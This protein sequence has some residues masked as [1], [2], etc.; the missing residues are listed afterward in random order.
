VPG[1]QRWPRRAKKIS[2]GA[3]SPPA[4]IL[5]SPM[6]APQGAGLRDAST[7]FIQT[8]KKFVFQQKCRPRPKYA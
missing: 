2:G 7:H 6:H 3:A 8:F 1:G 5:P 4:P